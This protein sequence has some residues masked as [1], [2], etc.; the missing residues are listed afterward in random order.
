MKSLSRRTFLKSTALAGASLTT[1]RVLGAN[2]D[3]RVAIIG[4]GNKGGQHVKVFSSMPGCR[5]TALCDVDP[6][7]LAKRLD[8]FEDKKAIFTTTD[9]RRVID[10]KDVDVVVIATCNH[11]HGPAAVW[12][13]QAG[14]DVY[15]EKPVSHSLREGSVM[16]AAAKK[17]NRI[18]QAGTQYRSDQGL[19]A[20]A[21][22]IKQGKIGKMLWG[23]VLWYE[24]RGSIG[25][26]APWMPDWLD[27]DLYCGP[28][29]VEPLTR[30]KLH[31]DWHW[32]WSTGDGDL[33]NSGIHAFDV[34]RMLAGYDHL[35]AR[36]FCTGGRF[37]VDDVGQTP[38]TQLTVLDYEPAPI[39]IENRNLPASKGQRSMDQVKGVREGIIFQCEHGYFA[40][41]RAGGWI[42]DNDG[43]KIKQF[44]GDGGSDHHANFIEAVRRRKSDVLNA[45][46]RQ[47]HISSAV[48]HLGNLSFRLGAD[49][50][51]KEIL[52]KIG[53]RQ[54][55]RETFER[56]EKHLAANEID[57]NR[58]PMKLGPWLTIDG[59]SDTITHCDGKKA[60][61]TI[62][63]ARELERGS[64]RKPF[65]PG[66]SI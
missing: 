50:G 35:P 28:A 5:V 14:K 20:A 21:D 36:S 15:V 48:C 22:Y 57:L 53:D 6:K 46:I 61:P 51:R 60:G 65:A 38:N 4:L 49:A 13:C 1:S 62:A 47:G 17:Y 52:E 37:A 11:W 64:Y 31:Y 12:S 23:H 34:C 54:L 33:A 26:K 29:P 32:V 2:D 24:R 7:R 25:K 19:R 40:G 43:K 45:P 9:L 30:D 41:F 44:K 8:P 18:V 10:R 59:Q 58:T 16:V 56:I 3:I 39:V 66:E 27:Y 63:K 55:A 42:F